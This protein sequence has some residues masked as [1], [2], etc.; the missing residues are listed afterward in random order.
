MESKS[1]D[2]LMPIAY[3]IGFDN[4]PLCNK[5]DHETGNQLYLA[6]AFDSSISPMVP[7]IEMEAELDELINAFF[8]FEKLVK[9]NLRKL[10]QVN[11]IKT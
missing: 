8:L 9:Y 7:V 10:I 6:P 4:R 5:W 1:L 11:R 3:T 2:Q